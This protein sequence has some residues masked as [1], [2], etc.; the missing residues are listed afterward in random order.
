M[1]S[2]IF[3]FYSSRNIV[4]DWKDKNAFGT[5]EV[6][7]EED[8]QQADGKVY[9]KFILGDYKWLSYNAAYA[10]V[11]RISNGLV[12]LGLKRLE[13]TI[14]FAETKADWMLSAQAC[15]VRNFPGRHVHNTTPLFLRGNQLS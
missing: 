4:D 13:R 12:G 2:N 14:I 6:L 15:F 8:E 11:M 1:T 10:K 9:K 3:P 7:S 5:R